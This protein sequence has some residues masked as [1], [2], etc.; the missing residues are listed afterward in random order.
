MPF[1]TKIGVISAIAGC[2]FAAS[3]TQKQQDP[4]ELKRETA[5]A[6]A[7]MKQDAKAV[8]Q[9]IQEGLTSD[10][11]VDLNQASKAEI[12]SLP[13]ISDGRADQIIAGRPYATTSELVGR[14]ILTQEEFDRV[15]DRV[16]VGKPSP[17]IR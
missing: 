3:C 5:Q 13:G 14:R 4:E 1:T 17:A 6:T 10:R 9:G 7:K 8:V 11:P 2:L 12:S 15:K 16:K